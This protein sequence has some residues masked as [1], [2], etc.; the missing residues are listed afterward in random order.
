MATKSNGER[1]TV[2]LKPQVSALVDDR[3][4]L[5][6]AQCAQYIHTLKRTSVAMHDVQTHLILNICMMIRKGVAQHNISNEQMTDTN[7]LKSCLIYVRNSSW[8]FLT[9]AIYFGSTV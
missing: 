2:K 5:R 7:D 4:S 6:I 1:K 3:K 8:F 9:N